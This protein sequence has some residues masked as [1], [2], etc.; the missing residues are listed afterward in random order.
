MQEVFSQALK[1]LKEA[2]WFGSVLRTQHYNLR[3]LQGTSLKIF[4][5]QQF[6]NDLAFPTRDL[7][8][9][10]VFSRGSKSMSTTS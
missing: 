3:H 6:A 8:H 9:S 4:S 10:S 1:Q 5:E 7:T 2:F